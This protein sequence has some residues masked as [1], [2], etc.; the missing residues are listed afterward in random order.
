LRQ[1][2]AEHHRRHDD[3]GRTG[4]RHVA[5]VAPQPQESEEDGQQS[6]RKDGRG[7]SGR[8]TKPQG[9]QRC[10][11]ADPDQPRTLA[12]LSCH[13]AA[14]FLPIALARSEKIIRQ[15]KLRLTSSRET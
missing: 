7:Y 1:C 12:G 9:Q 13:S 2:R 11:G 3:R 14:P 15:R 6:N 5:I 4:A 10:D 8:S